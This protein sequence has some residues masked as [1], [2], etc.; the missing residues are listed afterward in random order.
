[1]TVVKKLHNF[2]CGSG[3]LFKKTTKIIFVA[4][5]ILN[6]SVFVVLLRSKSTK[7]ASTADA[8]HKTALVRCIVQVHLT[9]VTKIAVGINE[10]NGEN[11]AHFQLIVFYHQ[12]N[13]LQ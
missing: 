10:S 2:F 3:I 6:N 1:M 4:C 8:A 11:E 7:T 9:D 13:S 12:A 5:G